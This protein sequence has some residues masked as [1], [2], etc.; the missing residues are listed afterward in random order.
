MSTIA[1]ESIGIRYF[2]T[3]AFEIVTEL[4][5]RVLIDPCITGWN[6]KNVAPVS[7]D[8]LTNVNLILVSHAAP[9]HYVDTL[10]LARRTEAQIVCDPAV[11]Y[12]LLNSGIPPE[13]L[14]MTA[15]GMVRQF[16]RVT[17]RCVESKHV[18]C[19]TYKGAYVTG[20]PLGFMLTTESGRTIYHPGDT[21]IFSDMRLFAELYRP[22]IGLLPIGGFPGMP[23][24]LSMAEAALVTQWM[25][26]RTIIPTH[27]AIGSDEPKQFAGMVKRKAP[28]TEVIVMQPGEWIS[29]PRPV[30]RA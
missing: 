14:H 2:A 29:L 6:G 12:I 8:E 28:D 10:E 18:S 17:V 30:V 23:A 25:G 20:L 27:Y 21:A 13:R 4:G 16:G 1:G 24:E 22:E 11:H 19:T 26:L 5:A 9:D 7:L 3:S 15:W